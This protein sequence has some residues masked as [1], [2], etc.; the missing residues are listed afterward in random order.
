[1][2]LTRP[3]SVSRMQLFNLRLGELVRL[4]ETF[5]SDIGIRQVEVFKT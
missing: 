3:V 2:I 5:Q 1:M 4:L